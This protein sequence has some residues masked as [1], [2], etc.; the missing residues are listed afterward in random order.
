MYSSLLLQSVTYPKLNRNTGLRIIQYINMRGH[1]LVADE[2]QRWYITIDGNEC[3]SP[4]T[5]ELLDYSLKSVDF[6]Q[7]SS[8]KLNLLCYLSEVIIYLSVKIR[9]WE[10]S[11][12]EIICQRWNLQMTKVQTATFCTANANYKYVNDI[13]TCVLIYACRSGLHIYICMYGYMY[14]IYM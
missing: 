6:H 10:P 2:C 5:I 3:A 13:H 9:R 1:Y 11:M 12:I 4:E 8:S 14:A 7:T